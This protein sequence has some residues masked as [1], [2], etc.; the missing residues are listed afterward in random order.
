[1]AEDDLPRKGRRPHPLQHCLVWS[2]ISLF[3]QN[4]EDAHALLSH[5][6]QVRLAPD[7]P[8]PE[9]LFYFVKEGEVHRSTERPDREPHASVYRANEWV[10]NP[11]AME[12]ADWAENNFEWS[13]LNGRAPDNF[14]MEFRE[15]S[16]A[17]SAGPSNEENRSVAGK[18]LRRRD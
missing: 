13:P 6:R 5:F 10:C 14:V 1:M 9:S 2:P 11:A 12:E 4:D 17:V 3:L 18:R 15:L 7:K 8:A 16:R